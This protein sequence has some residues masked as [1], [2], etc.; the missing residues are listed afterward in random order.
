VIDLDL[1]GHLV[2]FE[3]EEASAILPAALLDQHR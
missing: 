2:G 1:E 3:L